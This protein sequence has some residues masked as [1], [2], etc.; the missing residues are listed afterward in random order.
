[1]TSSTLTI[2]KSE[3]VVAPE[4]LLAECQSLARD[5]AACDPGMLRSYKHL[6]DEGY[7]M[8]LGDALPLERK[9]SF[10]DLMEA[11]PELMAERRAQVTARGR[12]QSE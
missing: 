7:A 5:M 4:N 9:Q 2:E 3:G 8:N 1:M 12:L 10:V 11:N 6:I